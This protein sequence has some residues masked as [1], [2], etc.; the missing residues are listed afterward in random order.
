MASSNKTSPSSFPNLR[1]LEAKDLKWPLRRSKTLQLIEALERH[2]STCTLALAE[3]SLAGVHTILEQ[4][5]L[6]NQYLAELK[7]KQEKIFEL[8]VTTEQGM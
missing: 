8:T 6:S 7:A 5:K 1:R 2:K 4:T 3:D